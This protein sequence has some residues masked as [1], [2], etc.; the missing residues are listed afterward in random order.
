M[1]NNKFDAIEVLPACCAVIESNSLARLKKDSKLLAGGFINTI[2]MVEQ[3]FKLGFSGIT[4]SNKELW[5]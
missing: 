2:N 5:Q 3:V 4:T 1:V